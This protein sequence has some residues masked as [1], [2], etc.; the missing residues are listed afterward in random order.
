[1]QRALEKAG[2]WTTH[3][4]EIHYGEWNVGTWFEGK[5]F[6]ILP[7]EL[8]CLFE[9]RERSLRKKEEELSSE[10]MRVYSECNR[11][12]DEKRMEMESKWMEQLE[13]DEAWDT[14]EKP[15]E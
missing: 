13:N 6:V 12:G 2:Q 7:E 11:E 4:A 14:G 5:R 3:A 9:E 10:W 15:R 1:M 8:R